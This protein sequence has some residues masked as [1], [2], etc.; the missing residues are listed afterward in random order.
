MSESAVNLEQ[1]VVDDFGEEWRR[2]PN[3]GRVRTSGELEDIFN[4]YFSAFPWDELPERARGFD[5]GCGTGRWAVRVATQVGAIVCIDPSPRALEVARENLK[6]LENCEFVESSVDQVTF[7][8]ESF[9]FGYSL[10]VLHH[11]PDTL[12]GLKACARLLKPGAPFL[13]YLYYR[14]DNR[15]KL[16]RGLWAASNYVRRVVSRLPEKPKF[17]VS[18]VLAAT[19]YWPLARASWAGEQL[20]FG[21]DNWPLSFYRDR[22]FYVMRN[23]ALDRFGTKLEQR[24]TRQEIALML[25]QSGFGGVEF[26]AHPPYWCA[27]AR[28]R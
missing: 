28:K 16:F 1:D 11:V 23:D 25:Q 6:G 13:V 12:E 22:S 17:I 26:N 15:P 5:M 18:D 9:D 20:G 10:G 2:F 14:F 3:S 7:P 8:P 4:R 24:F 19:L 21:V 27:V